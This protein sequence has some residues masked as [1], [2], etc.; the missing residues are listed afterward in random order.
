MLEVDATSGVPLA[1]ESWFPMAVTVAER[2][3][4]SG[5]TLTTTTAAV[6]PCGYTTAAV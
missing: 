2:I 3:V 1:G 6:V 5:S 4:S